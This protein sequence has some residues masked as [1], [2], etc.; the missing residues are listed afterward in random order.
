MI[1]KK[2]Y[3]QIRRLI[4]RTFLGFMLLISLGYAASDGKIVGK[5]IDK[6]TGNPLPGVNIIIVGT[7]MGAATDMEGDYY[8]INVAP[9]I[10]SLQA[11]MIGY[12][13]V[14]KTEVNVSVNHTTRVDF[15]LEE[16]VLEFGEAVTVVAERPL[17]ELDKT[18]S[19]V[20]VEETDIKS[21][22]VSQ[23]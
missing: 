23:L 19:R 11:S 16:T 2:A 20:V 10:Y 12:K 17:I 8:I 21:R 13:Q 3:L 9:G 4:S 22:P 18:S 7:E 14:I 1:S 5:V 6:K 15:E